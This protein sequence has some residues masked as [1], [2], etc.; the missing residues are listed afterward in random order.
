MQKTALQWLGLGC[1]VALWH[2]LSSLYP[3]IIIPSIAETLDRLYLILFEENGGQHIWMTVQRAVVGFLA[4]VSFGIGIGLIAGLNKQVRYFMTPLEQLML[5]IP[6]IAW[7]VLAL[8]WF[9]GEG[10]TSPA[11]TI[12]VSQFPVVYLSATQA[13]RTIDAQLLEMGRS[14]NLSP[15]EALIQI[16][17]GHILSY[18]YPAITLTFGTSWKVGVMAEVLGANN[19]IGAQIANA[20][21]NLETAD[22]FGWIIIAVGL[23]MICDKILIRPINTYNMKWR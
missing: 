18:T 12:F 5:S 8:I 22:V 14:F 13:V 16:G 3:S 15:I 19:G 10:I 7:I 20:R 17:G 21:V 1:V 23:Y 11:L 4:S 6:P 2:W 9:G